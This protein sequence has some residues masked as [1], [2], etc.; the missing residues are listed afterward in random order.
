MG[1]QVKPGGLSD[2]QYTGGHPVMDRFFDK[3]KEITFPVRIK[4]F[5]RD[6]NLPM[7]SNPDICIYLNV[8]L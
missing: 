8:A 2:L 5:K 4:V 7:F 1:G 6:Q 3:V